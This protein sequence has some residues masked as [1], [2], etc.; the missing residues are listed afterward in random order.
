MRTLLFF[1]RHTY[2]GITYEYTYEYY[3]DKENTLSRD[4]LGVTY[5]GKESTMLLPILRPRKEIFN[6]RSKNN[7]KMLLCMYK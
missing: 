5:R 3:L 2:N 1:L 7:N 6:I 4:H